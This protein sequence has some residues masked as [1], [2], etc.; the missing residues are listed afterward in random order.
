MSVEVRSAQRFHPGTVVGVGMDQ[1]KS[2]EIKR[3]KEIKGDLLLFTE[4]LRHSHA[5]EEIV[6]AEFVRY[7]GIPMFSSAQPIFTTT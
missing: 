7:R 4:P 5:K 1:D 3:I 6:S 2:F